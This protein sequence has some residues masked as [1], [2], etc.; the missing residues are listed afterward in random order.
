MIMYVL[1]TDPSHFLSPGR[2]RT[3]STWTSRVF[4]LLYLKHVLAALS[5][6]LWIPF[7]SNQ[8]L[9]LGSLLKN[10]VMKIS[11]GKLNFGSKYIQIWMPLALLVCFASKSILMGSLVPS[12]TVNGVTWI[13]AGGWE[14]LLWIWFIWLLEGRGY[15]IFF[16][17]L[18]RLWLLNQ[19][20]LSFATPTAL[21]NTIPISHPSCH[22]QSRVIQP[23]RWV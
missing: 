18:D 22:L 19:L 12:L 7:K 3:V 9:L 20:T 17:V 13:S 1:W 5:F 4:T 15:A 2:C 8:L 23:L 11:L 21:T 10:V 16:P 14:F 6:S